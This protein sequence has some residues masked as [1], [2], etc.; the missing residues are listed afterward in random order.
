MDPLDVERFRAVW[1]EMAAEVATTTGVLDQC[2]FASDGAG[3]TIM[4]DWVDEAAFR[5]FEARCTPHTERSS[6]RSGRAAAS[7]ACPWPVTNHGRTGDPPGPSTRELAA[8]TP[9]GSSVEQRAGEAM[10]IAHVADELGV[11]LTPQRITTPTGAQVEIDGV[12]EARTVL[13]EAWAHQGP[14]K[15]A[16]KNKVLADAFKLSWIASTLTSKPQLVLCSSDVAAAEP[17]REGRTWAAAALRDLQ[18]DIVVAALPDVTVQA[19]RF[20]KAGVYRLN[21]SGAL[22]VVVLSEEDAVAQELDAGS[23][24]HLSLEQLRFGVHAFGS[25]VMVIEGDRSGDGVDVPFNASGEGMDV[26]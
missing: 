6:D 5:A 21:G 7:A 26:G 13:V 10:M 1:P 23:S 4:S 19:P 25:P 15:P 14:P 12:D 24:V 2:L 8:T 9:P 17:F 18:I 16:Q 22:S 20:S 11:E 3:L